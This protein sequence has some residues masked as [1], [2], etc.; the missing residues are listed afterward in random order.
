MEVQFLQ[1]NRSSTKNLEN[2]LDSNGFICFLKTYYGTLNNRL[3][4]FHFK[5]YM[6]GPLIKFKNM[7]AARARMRM[8][9]QNF[10]A[11]NAPMMSAFRARF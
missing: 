6:N 1:R 3:S 4:T 10:R 7:G 2:L 5:K 11:R 8:G 9:I